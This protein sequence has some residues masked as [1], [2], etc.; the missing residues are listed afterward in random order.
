M[1]AH[2]ILILLSMA[3][4]VAP[5]QRLPVLQQI[6]LP[7]PYYYREMYLPQL[8]TGPSG[9]SWIPSSKSAAALASRTVLF[10]MQGA[11]WRQQLDSTTAEQLTD[12]PGYDYQPDVSP[13]G[14]WAVYSKYDRDAV[15][16]WLLDLASGTTK[17]LT[18]NRA[19][20]VEPRFSPDGTR[21]AFVSTEFNRR[22]HIFIAQFDAATGTLRSIQRLAGE[23]RS[24]LPRYYYSPFDHEISPT[25]SP[26]GR[27]IIYISNRGHIHGTGGFWR[28][29][30]Q[31]LPAPA[32][33]APG[34][35]ARGPFA[36]FS[37]PDVQ[38]GQD[39]GREIRYEETNW[40]ARPDWSPDGKRVVYASYLGRNWHQLWIMTAEGGDVFPLTYGDYDN[41]NP[42]WSPDGSQIAFISNRGGA[43]SLWIQDAHSG[44]ETELIARD[45]KYL[46]PHGELRIQVTD[47]VGKPIDARV[48][49]TAED[50]RAYAPANAWIAADDSFDRKERPFEAHYFDVHDSARLTVPVGKITVDA[51]HGFAYKPAKQQIT[52]T[53][54]KPASLR[55]QLQPLAFTSDHS[56]WISG[57]VHVHMNYAGAYRATPATLLAQMR[58]EDLNAV[59]NLIV[60]KEQRFPDIAYAS[61]LGKIDPVSTADFQIL[62][63]QEFHS[64]YWAHLGLL[65]LDQN[66]VI[67]GYAAYP[68]TPAASLFPTNA[69]VADMA[70][71]QGANVLVGYVHPFDEVPDPARD[72]ALTNELPLDVALGKVDYYEV[73]GFSDH[74]SS[75]A[76]WYRLLNLG[77]HIPAAA[78]TDAMTNYASL[79]GPVGLNRV[80]V[81]FPPA[82]TKGPSAKSWTMEQWLERLKR[83]RTFA[84]NGPLLRFSLGGQPIGSEI[85]LAAP[86]SVKF[87]ASMRSMVPIDHL[88]LVCNGEVA[89]ALKLAGGKASVDAFGT[90]FI[91]RSGWCVLR[92]WADH[93]ESQ[94]L[95]LYPYATT[96]PIYINVAGKPAS[97][98]EDAKYF[99]A[100]IDRVAQNA[101]NHTG[102]NSPE[103]KDTVLKHIADARKIYETKSKAAH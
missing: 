59:Q 14:K 92:A 86:Q 91:G 19:V 74:K 100:W 83:G 20:D 57:D 88:E 30:A 61:R 2:R 58:A 81:E 78:G 82:A 38:H 55:L 85:K 87:T 26:D 39:P 67:P 9:V 96:S 16:L 76:V 35:M 93:A 46:H 72:A 64:S 84:S 51:M 27:E 94:V 68:N 53:A 3:F 63:G 22:F 7:H 13:D 23:N 33:P 79:R 31:P 11:L 50:G 52:I 18:R 41:T 17:A 8:T 98:P 1:R 28:M 45:L 44:R 102:Y 60:N 6:D 90:V 21:I 89:Q 95:D 36:R 99:L 71:A 40:K 103:E 43:L 73:V 48:S 25:W 97:S 54:G 42:R 24:S 77:F 47:A 5:A 66:I 49:V 101:S 29:N 75:A 70:H 12:G 69:D 10:S 56:R 32:Q 65:H 37:Q 80:Y 34:P 62:H 4:A 15:E